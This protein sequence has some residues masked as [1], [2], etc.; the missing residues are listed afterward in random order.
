MEYWFIKDVIQFL[1]FFK[2]YFTI[3]PSLL[4]RRTHY[5]TIPAFQRS[6]WGEAPK[7]RSCDCKAH[8]IFINSRTEFKIYLSLD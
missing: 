6:N 3:N 4:Y 1:N 2:M 7:F 5:S 8:P